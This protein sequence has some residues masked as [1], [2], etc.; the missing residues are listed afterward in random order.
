MESPP[1]PPQEIE[2]KLACEPAALARVRRHPAVAPLLDGRARTATVVSRYY[3][4][5]DASPAQRRRHAATSPRGSTLAANGKGRRQRRRRAAPAH[6]IRMAAGATATRPRAVGHDAVE[7]I[8]RRGSRDL[9]PLFTTEV[10]RTSQP[11][12]FADGTRAA[13]VPGSSARSCR[14]AGAHRSAEV[15]IELVKATRGGSTT[16]RRRWPSI[17]PLR[18]AHLSK[19]ERGYALA[20]TGHVEPVRAARVPL[21]AEISA[22]MAFAAVGADC[23]R[24]IGANAEGL[25]AG[26][27]EEFVHQLRVGVRRLR[28]LLKFVAALIRRCRSTR[29]TRNCSGLPASRGPRATGTYSPRRRSP[30]S[31]RSWR[32]R[33]CA[34]TWDGSR[35]APRSCAAH[36][37]ALPSWRPCVRRASRACCSRSAP[38]SPAWR[39]TRRGATPQRPSA[40]TLGRDHPGATRSPV[41][42][43]QQAAARA[44]SGG[45]SPRTRSPPR[46][47]ATRRS[48]SR[49]STA[50]RVP[51]RYIDALARLQ[52]AL[53]KLNDLATAE[54]LLDELVPAGANA[55]RNAHAA[56]IVRG[57]GIA[58]AAIELARADKAAV[59]SPS[60]SRSGNRGE[61]RMLESAEIGH[62]ISEAAYTRARS[63]S[64]AKHCSMRSTTCRR[65]GRGPVLLVMSGVES[66]GRGETANKLTEWMDPRFIRVI[67]FGPRTAGGTRAPADVAL[68]ARAAAARQG[69]AFS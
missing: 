12:A 34:A 56:G 2:L 68:L 37:T 8:V 33:S 55:A 63:R 15:E 36:R 3:D 20:G 6:R 45:P 43:A 46:N 28:S 69:S 49:R 9:R 25:A 24:Q 17:F 53:G 64:C 18:V 67:A 60:S 52:G 31:R 57:W 23:L 32:S 51:P 54:R 65:S 48:F 26:G 1:N 38:C 19:A 16:S 7:K 13:L 11:L 29:S 50:A 66:G 47:F 35:R 4:T 40:R 14:A 41:A 5:P 44:R 39:G 10:R 59:R 21:A 58:A 30:R 42:Q 22:A 27:D 62:K 61:P